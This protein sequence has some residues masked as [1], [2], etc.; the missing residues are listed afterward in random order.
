MIVQLTA[1]GQALLEGNTGPVT[2]T[3]FQLG[4]A[5]GYVPEASDTGIHGTLVYTG[6]P[7]APLAVSANLVAYSSYLDYDLGPFEFGEIGL[8]VGS[9]LFALATGSAPISKSAPAAN[10]SGNSI[11]IDAYVSVV[12]TNYQMWLNLAE[13]SNA[14][15][16]AVLTSPDLLPQSHQAVPNAYII[17]GVV[18]SQSAF[19]AYTDKFGLWNFDAYQ[20]GYQ[21]HANVVTSDSQSVTIALDQFVSQMQPQY[22]GQVILEFTS[23]ALYSVCRYVETAIVS[24]NFVTLGFD[25]PIAMQPAAGDTFATFVRVADSEIP[26][27]PAATTSELG[28]VIVGEYLTVQ[29]NGLLAV[30][31]AALP[32]PVTSVN[33]LT[34]AVVV[35]ATNNNAA[36]G[37]SLISNSGATTGVIRLKTIVAGTNITIAPDSNGNL[38][39]SDTYALPIASLTTLGGVKAPSDGNITISA[40]GVID[41][42]F[43]P[44][45]SVD[46]MSGAV[47]LPLATAAAPGLMQVGTGLSVT[48][49]VVSLSAS[50]LVTSVSGQ[51]GDVVVQA[52]NNNSATG[53]SLITNSG[54]T[55]GN[56]KLKTIVAGTNITLATDA[57]GNLQINGTASPYTLPVATSTVL[58]GVKQGAG[59]SIAGD[60]TISVSGV[61]TSVSGQSGTVTVQASDNNAA[62]GTSLI[63]NSGATTANIKLKTIV[64]GS[65]ITLAADGNG[66]L[67][68]NSAAAPYTLPVATSSV[69]GGVKQGANVTIAGDG[70][71]SVAA[72]P[73]TSVNGQTGAVTIQAAD[74]STA[75]GTT[76]ISDNGTG[77]GTI[78]LRRIVAG[79][80]IAV[81]VDGNGNL[82]VSVA[83]QYYDVPLGIAGIPGASQIVGQFVAVRTMNFASNFVGS[84][85]FATASATASTTF[86]INR[87]RSGATTA[88]GTVVYAASGTAPTFT[89]TG[90]ATQQL[91]AGDILQA[92]A[93][94]TADATLANATFTLLATAA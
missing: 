52:T 82:Q 24:G 94:A 54:S 36:S 59:V 22:F 55:T 4:S 77:T 42:G 50:S 34:G 84:A 88:I 38:L 17:S 48:N 26:Q 45:T 64:A 6:V 91:I 93:P 66:N 7:S 46:G 16:M 35:Q 80:G 65:N 12:G 56:I 73:V 25:S 76:L 39:I 44:V 92:V 71:I 63:A 43:T 32:Y 1:A 85:G 78:K 13:S 31:A 33:G 37:V 51:T 62:T 58:G 27:F 3:S 83:S 57:N 75:S 23:G 89:T 18:N 67:Q 21:T 74:T 79:A 49:G 8:Y 60:G 53:V 9:T 40:T 15:Q 28:G 10:T 20:Y 72:S 68:I 2:V 90:S 5:Y 30:D 81:A 87:I 11:R 47:T 14:F 29:P 19:L 61:V 41:L 70:T 86:T 69:L